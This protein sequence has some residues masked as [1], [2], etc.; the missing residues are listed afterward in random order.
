MPRFIWI[1][2]YLDKPRRWGLVQS[3]SAVCSVEPA[4]LRTVRRVCF[5]SG[6][7]QACFL[8]ARL[9]T[10]EYMWSLCRPCAKSGR[11]VGLSKYP[12]RS[13]SIQIKSNQI[14]ST[15]GLSKS[16]QIESP[17]WFDLSVCKPGHRWEI[18][19]IDEGH[20]WGI[21]IRDT[22]KTLYVLRMSRF[23]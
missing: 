5:L 6:A 12:N 9:L 4:N 15:M 16:N 3:L 22:D 1:F 19:N 13:K 7:S 11:E 10:M 21:R 2:D 20:G 8:Q 14:K 23:Q 17:I 18:K